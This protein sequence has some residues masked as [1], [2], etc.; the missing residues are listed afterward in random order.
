M[1]IIDT[2]ISDYLNSINKHAGLIVCRPL[3][4]PRSALWHKPQAAR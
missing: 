1:V 3:D 4:L 2:P